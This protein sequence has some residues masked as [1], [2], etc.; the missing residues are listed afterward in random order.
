[1]HTV[2]SFFS[3]WLD[4]VVATV[5]CCC[6]KISPTGF[7]FLNILNRCMQLGNLESLKYISN[8]NYS[9]ACH[10]WHE[11]CIKMMVPWKHN[12]NSK[13]LIK[14]QGVEKCSVVDREFRFSFTGGPHQ[15]LHP[16][17]AVLVIMYFK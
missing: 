11:T 13:R 17:F 1:M 8:T 14:L 6:F 12:K 10:H 4:F 15:Y 5:Y 16:S 7:F 2:S 9:F 3:A